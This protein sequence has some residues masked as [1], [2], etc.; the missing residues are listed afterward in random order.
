MPRV[1][2]TLSQLNFVQLKQ[3]DIKESRQSPVSFVAMRSL[4]LN[5]MP[6]LTNLVPENERKASLHTQQYHAPPQSIVCVVVRLCATTL[7]FQTSL[8]TDN[9]EEYL[10]VGGSLL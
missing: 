9:A 5:M 2:D 1:F 7:H 4:L 3:R 8:S 10:R 6:I